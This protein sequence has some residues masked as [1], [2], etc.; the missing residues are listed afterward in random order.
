[1]YY[2]CTMYY[3]LLC[4]MKIVGKRHRFLIC[5]S[6]VLTRI[7][8]YFQSTD[9]RQINIKR[10]T[11]MTAFTKIYLQYRRYIHTFKCGIYNEKNDKNNCEKYNEKEDK[12]MI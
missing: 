6:S 10:Q 1:M 9:N 12:V 7:K 2:D 8:Y 3:D 11:K 5:Y 4:M